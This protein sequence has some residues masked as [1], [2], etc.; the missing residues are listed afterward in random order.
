MK[1]LGTSLAISLLCLAC[2]SHHKPPNEQ[3]AASLKA[4]QEAVPA[5]VSDPLQAARLNKVI[6]EPREPLH[7]F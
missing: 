4:M 6:D 1:L 3:V 2:A 5:N 7:S